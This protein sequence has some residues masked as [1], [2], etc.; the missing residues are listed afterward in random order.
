MKNYT[1]LLT[2]AVMCAVILTA[3]NKNKD[4]NTNNNQANSQETVTEYSA[5]DTD[6]QVTGEVT[7]V[8]GNEITLDLGETVEKQR[9]SRDENS[10][11]VSDNENSE[12]PSGEDRPEMPSGDM[13][14]ENM[15]EMPSGENM[16]GGQ[17]NKN[18]AS[19]SIDKTGESANY[20]IPVGMSVTGSSGRDNDYSTISIGTAVKVT[21]NSDGE[22]VACEIL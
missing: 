12:I 16:Q 11:T 1:K 8:I 6:T 2:V 13:N 15:P 3:C 17:G 18:K 7:A 20:I 21:L 4:D 10:D 19:V 5:Q 14:F 22:V 9:P